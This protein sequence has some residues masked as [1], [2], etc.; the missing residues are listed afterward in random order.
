[1]EKDSEKKIKL[2][3][4]LNGTLAEVKLVSMFG[5]KSFPIDFVVGRL[6]LTAYS[7]D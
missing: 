7:P 2:N 4:A 6:E 5:T 1:M 3:R